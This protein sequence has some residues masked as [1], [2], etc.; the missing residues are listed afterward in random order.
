MKVVREASWRPAEKS[1]RILQG[2]L[3][4]SFSAVELFIQLTGQ[5]SVGHLAVTIFEGKFALSPYATYASSYK[6]YSRPD[7][8]AFY[9]SL[10]N[11]LERNHC[12]KT[13]RF[14]CNAEQVSAPGEA[15]PLSPHERQRAHGP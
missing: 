14:V 6:N 13:R 3:G 5:R 11:I 2:R 9:A 7:S 12:A 15:A 8:A 10:I 4:A 1:S